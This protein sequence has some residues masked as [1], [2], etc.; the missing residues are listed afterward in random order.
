MLITPLLAVPFL[1][2]SHGYTSGAYELLCGDKLVVTDAAL[3][4][5]LDRKY[6]NTPQF[7]ET[8]ATFRERA[9]SVARNGWTKSADVAC[10]VAAGTPS[11][12][13][14]HSLRLAE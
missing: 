10:A 2:A 8:Y 1:L 7:K 13:G 3:R 14:P 12:G 5:Q 4:A 6:R 11:S 9:A